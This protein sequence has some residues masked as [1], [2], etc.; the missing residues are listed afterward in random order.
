M[1]LAV[2][3]K[4]LMAENLRQPHEVI[5]VVF[6]KLV[7]HRVPQQVRMELDAGDGAVL[8]AHGPHASVSQW[9]TLADEHLAGLHG[10]AGVEVHLERTPSRKGQRHRSLLVALA[11]SEDDGAA[12][13]GQHQVSQFEIY[14]I[15]NTTAGVEQYREDGS[16]PDVLP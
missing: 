8:V 9:P 13:F 11:E 14:K 10:R 6:E 2:V 1:Y 7:R 5:A 4:R 16:R 15:G 3:F 12:A